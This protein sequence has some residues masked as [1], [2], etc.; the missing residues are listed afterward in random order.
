MVV[1]VVLILSGT[2]GAF[3]LPPG[4][5]PVSTGAI[6]GGIPLVFAGLSVRKRYREISDAASGDALSRTGEP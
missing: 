1:G 5:I 6:G 4:S 3:L 2:A